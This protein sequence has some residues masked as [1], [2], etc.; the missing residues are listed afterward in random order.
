MVK[1]CS[2]EEGV[3]LIL[4]T[5]LQFWPYS[6]RDRHPKL[7]LEHNPQTLWIDRLSPC[8]IPALSNLSNKTDQVYTPSFFISNKI[9]DEGF[10]LLNFCHFCL[11]H[12][13]LF[14]NLKKTRALLRL[15]QIWMEWM[16]TPVFIY[17]S[18]A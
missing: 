5:I 18:V 10:K 3:N 14:F 9:F 7:S 11:F 12:R 2:Q 17:S 15:T 6:W 13:D 1:Y 8:I 16:K 4:I